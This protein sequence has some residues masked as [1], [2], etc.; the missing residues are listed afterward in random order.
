VPWA[1]ARSYTADFDRALAIADQMIQ[2]NPTDLGP[3]LIKASYQ[4]N[5]N[6]HKAAKETLAVH[7]RAFEAAKQMDAWNYAWMAALLTSGNSAGALDFA[8]NAGGTDI[9]TRLEIVAQLLEARRLSGNIAEAKRRLAQMYSGNGDPRL[10]LL[11]TQQQAADGNWAAIGERSVELLNL[12]PTPDALYFVLMADF[13]TRAYEQCLSRTERFKGLFPGSRWPIDVKRL[14]IGCLERS[15]R[16]REALMEAAELRRQDASTGTL[17]SFAR[18]CAGYGDM[19]AAIGA[20]VELTD[21]SDL[22]VHD[23]VSLAEILLPHAPQLSRKL[24]R[25]SKADTIPEDQLVKALY[26]GQRLAIDNEQTALRARLESLV[27]QE[28][29][30]IKAIRQE[31]IASLVSEVQQTC[32]QVL[33]L[34]DSGLIPIHVAVDRCGFNLAALLLEKEPTEFN[35]LRQP[36]FFTLHGRRASQAHT[37]IPP[38]TTGLNLD[39]TT[40]FLIQ[41]FKLWDALETAYKDLRCSHL[42]VHLLNRV[43][44]SLESAAQKREAGL[45]ALHELF[46]NGRITVSAEQVDDRL[47]EEAANASVATAISTVGELRNRGL[48]SGLEYATALE[49]L[50]PASLQGDGAAALPENGARIGSSRESLIRLAE[51]GALEPFAT[52]FCVVA[53]PSVALEIATEA[54]AIK[55]G[56]RL[57]SSVKDLIEA[58]GERFVSGRLRAFPETAETPTVSTYAISAFVQ[59]NTFTPNGNELIVADDRQVNSVDR[60]GDENSIAIVTLRDIIETLVQRGVIVRNRSWDF[61]HALRL[62]NCRFVPFEPLEIVDRL[63]DAGTRDGRLLDNPELRVMR[64]HI[65]ACIKQ[66]RMLQRADPSTASSGEMGVAIAFRRSVLEALAL[67]WSNTAQSS[68]ARRARATWLVESLYVDWSGILNAVGIGVPP[69]LQRQLAVTSAATLLMLN[70]GADNVPI[71]NKTDYTAWIWNGALRRR[72]NADPTLSVEIAKTIA[73]AL[74]QVA[75]KHEAGERSL[76]TAS[77]LRTID[78]LPEP[79]KSHAKAEIVALPEFA[80]HMRRV[81]IAADLEFDAEAFMTQVATALTN[82]EAKMS[83]LRP[84]EEVTIHRLDAGIWDAIEIE[85]PIK[86]R[87]DRLRNTLWATLI[88]S[89]PDREDALRRC[90]KLFDVDDA[91]FE[92][93]LQTLAHADNAFD[94]YEAAESAAGES[95]SFYYNALQG[96]V[97]N[98]EELSEENLLPDNASAFSRY[99]GDAAGASPEAADLIRESIGPLEK[100]VGT[101][102]AAVRLSAL[103]IPLPAAIEAKFQAE[104]PASQKEFLHTVLRAG[105]SPIHRIHALRL[106]FLAVPTAEVERLRRWLLRGYLGPTQLEERSAFKSV[107]TWVIDQFDNWHDARRRS[108]SLRLLFSWAH[109]S[110]LFSIY[111]KARAPVDWLAG[112]FQKPRTYQA[113]TDVEEDFVNGSDVAAPD[114]DLLDKMMLGG[115]AYALPVNMLPIPEPLARVCKENWFGEVGVPHA[116]FL[117]E[118]S[119]RPN[120]LGSFLGRDHLKDLGSLLGEELA[121]GYDAAW[122]SRLEKDALREITEAGSQVTAWVILTAIYGNGPAPEDATTQIEQALSTV[123]FRAVVEADRAGEQMFLFAM[124]NRIAHVK[125]KDARAYIELSL[126]SLAEW[127]GSHDGSEQEAMLILNLVLALAYPAAGRPSSVEEFHQ[128]C[129]AVA[130]RFRRFA[131]PCRDAVDRFC[132]DL[133]VEKG[134][135]F[136]PLALE[137]R[138]IDPGS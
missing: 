136:W 89:G 114:V 25:M 137:L 23:A 118:Q 52:S 24:L 82:G 120:A 109:A 30:P 54:A 35:P 72:C 88:E 76:L 6:D 130:T 87:V 94:R 67:V 125:G 78:T 80:E 33:A 43:L 49:A 28:P 74:S 12:L 53:D 138:A 62:S 27:L 119:L 71:R 44:A 16:P 31:D 61:Y 129:V 86:R 58:L 100:R 123:D 29:S 124:S 83:S 110:S 34:Y 115:L 7:R 60:R 133:P 1:I 2:G 48:I 77:V 101:I 21:R 132:H 22:P 56:R 3:I 111:R 64:Q 26:L 18:L 32:D 91:G 15:G 84:A 38:D 19:R 104:E 121:G 96:R 42:I 90:R 10:L 46:R 99:Y 108:R 68:A 106:A 116:Y 59:L 47:D 97:K 105:P 85:R 93:L 92:C 98:N 5:T 81:L 134:T 8:R 4:A 95:L 13:E 63:M 51:A 113:I 75:L 55:D 20:A 65:A 69:K 103:P 37:T 40:I 102:E 73:T 112:V 39:L 50:G 11:W 17:A 14:R 107:F 126:L 9:L 45:E 41:K 128:L 117:D 122:R 135:K 127:Y 131:G 70:F 79:V 66:G 36:I 57:S